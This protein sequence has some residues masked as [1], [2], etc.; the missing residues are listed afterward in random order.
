MH[1]EWTKL[2]T[3]PAV[4]WLL[5]AVVV[6]PVATGWSTSAL[7]ECAPGAC[8]R[9][10][11]T[12]SLVGV[13][14]G[15]VLVAALAVVV[16]GGEYATGMMRTTLTAVPRR[17]AVLGAKALVVGGTVAVAGAVAVA[18]SLAVGADVLPSGGFVDADGAPL[19]SLTAG[20]TL[21]AGVGTV[22]YLVLVALLAL[23]VTVA[24]RD[25][26]AATGIVLAALYLVPLL[27]QVVSDPGWQRQL[28]RLGPMPAGLAVQ[29]TTGL[30][31]LPIGPWAGLGV[32][33]GWTAAA[34]AI[35]TATFVAR[36]A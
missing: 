22:L 23:G 27:V 34:L 13:H 20:A 18:A 3:T 24:V 4:G 8:V 5:V 19:L 11:A 29:A 30:D 32:L 16:V 28:E 33:A 12:I 2:R 14:I 17:W 9:D 10:P 31:D 36:D 26:A 35:G 7:S 1:A 15:Q 6:A 21:R 25:P